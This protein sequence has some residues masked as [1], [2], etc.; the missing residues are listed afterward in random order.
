MLP[1]Y[2]F[3]QQKF[4]QG[5]IVI[6][7][8]DHLQ[9]LKCR[10]SLIN[11][12]TELRVVML[13][14]VL[15]RQKPIDVNVQNCLAKEKN[16]RSQ[17]VTFSKDTRTKNWPLPFLA[18]LSWKRH[19]FQYCQTQTYCKKHLTSHRKST[20]LKI[21]S[22]RR[23]ACCHCGGLTTSG[24]MR[25]FGAFFMPPV[26]TFTPTLVATIWTT[27]NHYLPKLPL[28]HTHLFSHLP[29]F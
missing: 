23:N 14:A 4:L 5:I 12:F 8:C 20:I 16:Q 22:P 6:T 19:Y 18:S 10:S 15:N 21:E 9:N 13:T 17:F 7:N 2:G 27:V 26:L 1:D 11:T 3:F 28:Y 29:I 24:C 25:R